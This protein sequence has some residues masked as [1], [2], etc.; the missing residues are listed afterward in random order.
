MKTERNG[1]QYEIYM[2]PHGYSFSK[3]VVKRRWSTFEIITSIITLGIAPAIQSMAQEPF[4]WDVM[5]NWDNG[6]GAWS[7]KMY[8]WERK[9]SKQQATELNNALDQYIRSQQDFV[10]MEIED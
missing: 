1:K 8:N 3:P 5:E 9:T 10:S 6:E 7:S 4:G 2:A